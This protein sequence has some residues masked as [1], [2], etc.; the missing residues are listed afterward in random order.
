MDQ[1]VIHEIFS[2][3]TPLLLGITVVICITWVA[4]NIVKA[5]KQRAN[6]QTKTELYS[7]M[8][9]KF[10]AAPEFIAFLQTEEGR[11]LIEENITQSAQPMRKILGSIQI[12]IILILLGTGLLALGN[13]FGSSLGGDL[14]IVLTV[15]GTVG[16]MVGIGLLISVIIS[17]QLSKAWGLL[18]VKE[19][20]KAER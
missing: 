19:K 14:Y 20:E 7:R 10:G 12:G 6:L 2:N 15:S 16:L 5:L 3:L 9:D 18:P 17:Y 13:I 8:I 11:H 1:I 4:V